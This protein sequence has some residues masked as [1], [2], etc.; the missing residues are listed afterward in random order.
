MRVKPEDVGG[1]LGSIVLPAAGVRGL[2]VVLV[3]VV[4]AAPWLATSAGLLQVDEGAGVGGTREVVRLRP[5]LVLLQGGRFMMGSPE[6]EE[7]RSTDEVQHEVELSPFFMCRTEVTNEQWK[8]VMGSSPSDCKYG[9]EDNQPVQI[10]TWEQATEYMNALTDRENALFP[11][12][13]RTRCYEG[14]T[15]VEGC[16]GYR[17]PSEAE[18]ED[19]ARA[20]TKTAHSFGDDPVKLGEYAWFT[21]NSGDKAHPVG[22]KLP[23]PWGL[24]DM[25]GNVWEWVWDRYDDKYSDNDNDKVTRDPR[26]PQ[27]GAERVLRG[28]SFWGEPK[29]RSAD[30]VRGGPS[31]AN[32]GVGFRCARGSPPAP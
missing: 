31:D 6:G 22:E 4:L 28:G 11:K 26:G 16:T 2:V 14:S 7:G 29:L 30:R 8:A 20:G 3:A 17:L 9:C 24:Y 18:W 25:H 23:N 13:P 32:L 27:N 12:E 1:A 21:E 15:W 5:E 19:A 10:V